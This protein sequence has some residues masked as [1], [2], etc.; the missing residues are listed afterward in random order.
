MV[1]HNLSPNVRLRQNYTMTWY[2]DSADPDR[3]GVFPLQGCTLTEVN[4]ARQDMAKHRRGSVGAK[5]QALLPN[6]CKLVAAD[7][8]DTLAIQASDHITQR[9][10]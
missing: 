3:V 10:W 4:L 2:R 9:A 6:Y 7:G 5:E 1:E 8:A